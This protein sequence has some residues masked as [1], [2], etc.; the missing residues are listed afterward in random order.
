MKT[1]IIRNVEDAVVSR[2]TQNAKKANCTREEYLRR[3]LC[4]EVHREEVEEIVSSHAEVV[5]SMA[6][7]IVRLREA[8]NAAAE[9]F[10]ILAYEVAMKREEKGEDSWI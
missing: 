3:L 8:L 10:K 7:E 6:D 2:L 9:E 4:E 1:I 5:Y